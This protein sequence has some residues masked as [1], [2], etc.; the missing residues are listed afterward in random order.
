LFRLEKRR[1]HG[2]LIAGFQ[3]AKSAYKKDG[4]TLLTRACSD[5]QRAAVLNLKRVDLGWTLRRSI[6][7]GED[8]ETLWN[9]LPR[10]VVAA[11]SLEVFKIS[12]DRALSNLI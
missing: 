6:F 4:E 1:L 3:H 8:G 12:L 7:N 11:P 5:R 2:D 10:G 9:R